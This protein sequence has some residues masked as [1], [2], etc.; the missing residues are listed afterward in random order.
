MPTGR[1][2]ARLKHQSQ[3][4]WLMTAWDPCSGTPGAIHTLDHLYQ[5]K[6]IPGAQETAANGLASFPQQI[7]LPL[8]HYGSARDTIFWALG[9]RT[10]ATTHLR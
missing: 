10:A 2:A 1:L 6:S 9:C 7:L 3:K 4:R 5:A 8:P